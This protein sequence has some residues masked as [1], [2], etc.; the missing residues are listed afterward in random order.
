MTP[1]RRS[2]WAQYIATGVQF[3]IKEAGLYWPDDTIIVAKTYGELSDLD[4]IIGMKIYAMDMPSSYDFFL[5]F[6]MEN[7][8]CTKLQKA[9]LEY[10]NLYDLNDE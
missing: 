6:P 8:K 2:Q 5:A 9:F 1:E 7:V 3:A 4:E 10:T